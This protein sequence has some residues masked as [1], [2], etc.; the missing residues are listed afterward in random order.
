MSV[1]LI[2]SL[3]HAHVA[4]KVTVV[5]AG[6]YGEAA[7]RREVVEE[8]PEGSTVKD[9]VSRLASRYGGLFSSVIEPG[10]GHISRNVIL[11]VNSATVYRADRE[12][13]DGDRVTIADLL[14]V[15]LAGG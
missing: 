1:Q 8:L 15:S 9:L 2:G 10:H 14:E 7:G 12:L 4:L 5:L 3:F 6:E 11:L 13:K